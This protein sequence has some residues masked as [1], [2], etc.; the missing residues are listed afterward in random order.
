LRLVDISN[1]VLDDILKYAD[2]FKRVVMIWLVYWWRFLCA[3]WRRFLLMDASI[4]LKRCSSADGGAI[5]IINNPRLFDSLIQ[6]LRSD[7]KSSFY[8][9]VPMFQANQP[10]VQ[11]AWGVASF[12][13]RPCVLSKSTRSPLSMC[14]DI[15]LNE[16]LNFK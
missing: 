7:S 15:F 13:M 16:P 3:N 8:K 12:Q 10:A 6:W 9:W 5:Y 1:K 2:I 11:I 4:L 14:F